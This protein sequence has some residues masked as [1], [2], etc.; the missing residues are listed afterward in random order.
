MISV[1]F[2]VSTKSDTFQQPKTATVA[3]VAVSVRQQIETS[4][5]I[6]SSAK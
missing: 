5:L 2:F 1:N 6:L 4:T 3:T